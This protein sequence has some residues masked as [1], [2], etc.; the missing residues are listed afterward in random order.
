MKDFEVLRY[1][2][3]RFNPNTPDDIVRYVERMSRD[4]NNIMMAIIVSIGNRHI[5]N[6][7]IASINWHH[8]FADVSLLVG[9]KSLWGRA[10]PRKPLSWLVT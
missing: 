2:E 7:K 9:E 5:G 6:I 1:L 10:T 3:S 8:H 4:P